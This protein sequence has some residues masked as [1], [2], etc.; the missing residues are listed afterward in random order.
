MPAVKAEPNPVVSCVGIEAKALPL[1]HSE[2]KLSQR[3]RIEFRMSWP[4]IEVLSSSESQVES[5]VCGLRLSGSSLP[6]A[7]A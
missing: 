1:L 4:C 2:P 6:R 3:K 5:Q 7:H